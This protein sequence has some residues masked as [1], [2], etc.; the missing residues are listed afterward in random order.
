MSALIAVEAV[1]AAAGI[2]GQTIKEQRKISIEYLQFDFVGLAIK[3]FLWFMIAIVIDKIHFVITGSA[4][5][6]VTTIVNVFGYNLP[7]A[8]SE[9]DFFKKLFNEGYFG[10]KYWDFIK[11]GA[12]VLVLIEF[13][14]W[15]ENEI[16]LAKIN[17]TKPQP[18]YFTVGIFATIMIALSSFTIPD[19]IK[20]LKMRMPAGGT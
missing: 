4:V 15:Y 13:A 5:N 16:K 10:L 3:L 1:K 7:T 9:P 11:I 12:L 14:R 6:V 8:Q 2:S 18:N 19:I 20:K 17:G